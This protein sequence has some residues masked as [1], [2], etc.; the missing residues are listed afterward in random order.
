MKPTSLKIL[1][2]LLVGALAASP[3]WAAE[4][5]Q[6]G[7]INYVEGQVSLNGQTLGET[8][9]GSARL[10]AGESLGTQDGRAEVLLT[11]GVFLRVQKNSTVE[12]VS[13]DLANTT[14]AVQKGRALIEV[15]EIHPENDLRIRENGAS[16]RIL[17]AGLYDFDADRRSVR[18]FDGKASLQTTGRLLEV[19]SGRQ[20][21]LNADG[22]L[23]AQKFDKTAYEDDFY[24][25][26]SLR[27]SYLT[28]A[29]VDVARRYAGGGGWSP[30]VWYGDGWY[31]DPWFDAYT[32]LPGDG[33]FYSPFGW[34]FYSPWFAYGA[35]Y[36]GY[37]GGYY[38]HFGP[39]YQPRYFAGMG[40]Y[41]SRGHAYSVDGTS[42]SSS[43]G[44]GGRSFGGGSVGGV[45][46]G[47]GFRGSSFGGGGGFHGGG[48][49]G[50]FH[51]G[52]SGRR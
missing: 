26:S 52:G 42:G 21:N 27:S 1:M 11:P 43:R 30:N 22:K 33:I 38:R 32:F 17:K 18:V 8:S 13:P 10:A 39:G 2:G 3:I 12:M 44:F 49:G 46:G 9:V 51:G 37:A 41:G 34:G 14:V 15:T 16:V 35:P 23:K 19:K 45:R 7:T 31:W 4:P 5:A 48:F 40:A 25:W 24:R 36:F 20:I 50:G 6:P 47:G 28:E 29:N